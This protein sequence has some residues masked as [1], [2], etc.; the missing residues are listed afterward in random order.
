[1]QQVHE[2]SRTA[3]SADHFRTAANLMANP[4]VIKDSTASR[5]APFSIKKIALAVVND[6]EKCGELR[7]KEAAAKKEAEDKATKEQAK[8]SREAALKAEQEEKKSRREAEE[9]RKREEQDAKRPRTPPLP[10]SDGEEPDEPPTEDFDPADCA[11]MS[12]KRRGVCW[13]CGEGD[14]GG[15]SSYLIGCEVCSRLFHKP[16]IKWGKVQHAITK[17]IKWACI[18]CIRTTSQL[19]NHRNSMQPCTQLVR[20][21]ERRRRRHRRHQHHRHTGGQYNDV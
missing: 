7:E 4:K 3:H 1:M 21:P 2:M 11:W 18:G 10:D 15:A 14:K 12:K 16:C 19:L 13:D 20:G 5:I 6:C 17:Q 8:K 9:K